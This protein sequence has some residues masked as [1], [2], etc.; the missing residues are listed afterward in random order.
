M[1]SQGCFT[2][3]LMTLAVLAFS[4]EVRA[5]E[6]PETENPTSE[7]EN[8]ER[9]EP[10]RR[11]DWR[12]TRRRWFPQNSQTTTWTPKPIN[13]GWVFLDGQYLSLPY[14]FEVSHDSIKINGIELPQNVS[15]SFSDHHDGSDSFG[16]GGGRSF[17]WGS[18]RNQAGDRLMSFLNQTDGIL[19]ASKDQE[20]VLLREDKQGMKL[21]AILSGHS[22]APTATTEWMQQ[23]PDES[24][25]A[26]QS[27][28]K[29]FEA[30][31]EFK[32]R[33]TTT[34]D[35]RKTVEAEAKR[36][37]SAVRR[38]ET[39]NYPL[40]ICAMLL[41][42]GA[43]GHLIKSHPSFL[44][45]LESS[46]TVRNQ[47]FLSLGLAALFSIHDLILTLLAL[48][49]GAMREANPIAAELIHNPFLLATFKVT[50]TVFALG[51]MAVFWKRRIAQTASWWTCL[52]LTLLT[53][54]WL[55]VGALLA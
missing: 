13:R 39:W 1:S 49:A 7:F 36:Q 5:A 40:S 41:C 17:G 54:R 19:I 44:A 3:R 21:L 28:I 4:C 11:D 27:L 50:L 47:I 20:P 26:V 30:T 15:D 6:L 46:N 8:N 53:A 37:V 29:S 42:V 51:V 31:E 22:D 18:R 14:V 55:I 38:L 45:S 33:A 43:F 9:P 2:I 25:S 52:I 32:T 48:D 10:E 35:E 16:R 23:I 34:I 12:P 24:R